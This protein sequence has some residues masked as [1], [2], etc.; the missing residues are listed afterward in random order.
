MFEQGS[1]SNATWPAECFRAMWPPAHLRFSTFLWLCVLSLSATF[2][3]RQLSAQ[4]LQVGDIHGQLTD[5]SSAALLGATVTLTSPALLVPRTAVTDS[6]GNYR[7]EQLPLGT[8]KVEFSGAGF[9][10]TAR[11]NIVITA[12]FSA[13]VNVQMGVQNVQQNIV[14]SATQGR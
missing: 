12:G 8:Y 2:G 11:E 1:I 7:F 6:Y 13:E 14:V 3:A 10:P 4:T 5:P 9:Q